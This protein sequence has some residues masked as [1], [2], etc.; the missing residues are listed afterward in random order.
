MVYP[1]PI[2]LVLYK[3][4]SPQWLIIP[5][6]QIIHRSFYRGIIKTDRGMKKKT[7]SGSTWT[8]HFHILCEYF[9]HNWMRVN[10]VYPLVPKQGSLES[11]N[12][13]SILEMV[14]SP[15]RYSPDFHLTFRECS[16]IVRG[17]G[18][19]RNLGVYEN[20][21]RFGSRLANTKK[22]A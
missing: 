17:G 14:Q 1:C 10:K 20:Y 16:F 18:M 3:F 9:F 19:G 15:I 22:G 7:I 2:F 13:M 8:P 6:Y 21:W 12:F 11:L 4:H 5:S